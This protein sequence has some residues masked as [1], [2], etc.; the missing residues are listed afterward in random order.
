MAQSREVQ[1]D[2]QRGFKHVPSVLGM[3]NSTSYSRKLA[4]LESLKRRNLQKE[5]MQFDKMNRV[6]PDY[7]EGWE[8]DQRMKEVLRKYKL[9][10]MHTS[11]DSVDNRDCEALAVNGEDKNELPNLQVPAQVKFAQT[12]LCSPLKQAKSSTRNTSLERVIKQRK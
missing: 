3:M 8:C 4:N 12:S 6:S 7:A 2:S 10:E 1:Y 5:L 11:I 9:T